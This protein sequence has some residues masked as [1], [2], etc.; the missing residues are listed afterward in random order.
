MGAEMPNRDAVSSWDALRATLRSV[1]QARAQ[2]LG[3]IDNGQEDWR[4]V[5]LSALKQFVPAAPLAGASVDTRMLMLEGCDCVVLLDGV[6]LRQLSDL[7]GSSRVEVHDY[8]ELPLAVAAALGA[9]WSA[10]L[11]TETDL[12]TCWALAGGDSP[13]GTGG[14]RIRV[15]ATSQ[16]P[17]RPL[18][19]L[20]LSSGGV[21]GGVVTVEV[22]RGCQLHLSI[23]HHALQ[24]SR[25][26]L[27]VDVDLAAGA[28]LSVDDLQL[29]PAA[30]ASQLFCHVRAQCERDSLLRWTAARLGAQLGR[31]RVDALLLAPGA[32][33]DLASVAELTLERQW[34][35]LT[36]VEHRVGNTTSEQLYKTVADH[37]AIGSFDG[38]VAIKPGA[39][40][41]SAQQRNHSLLLSPK[42]RVD[43]RPQLDIGADDVKASHGSSIGALNADEVFYLKTRGLGEA[44]ARGVLMRGFVQD[45][46]LRLSPAMQAAWARSSQH[47]LIPR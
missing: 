21:S 29:G 26:S 17:P 20:S 46:T 13:S 3:S 40:L 10:Q 12:P 37:A 43:S 22:E 34:H 15:S 9:R 19:L 14:C 24:A 42:A 11:Q 18:H 25:S 5:G 7:S 2:A 8:A 35:D 38:L 31:S 23:T 32:H 36:R 44:E 28:R 41:S 16:A 6:F 45:I 27:V 4:Y 39:D 30:S 33:C 47:D 1:A